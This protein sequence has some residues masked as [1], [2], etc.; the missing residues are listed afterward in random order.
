MPELDQSKAALLA[1]PQPSPEP[2][3]SIPSS[4]PLL[5][6][7]ALQT[8][9]HQFIPE[10]KTSL[11]TTEDFRSQSLEKENFAFLT[12]TVIRK[13]DSVQR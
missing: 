7:D 13:F 8:P 1:T 2:D 4:S 6:Q 10:A 9:N 11:L 5:L 3:P 12:K